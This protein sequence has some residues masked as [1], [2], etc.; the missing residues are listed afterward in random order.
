MIGLVGENIV[1]LNMTSLLEVLSQISGIPINEFK[2]K[3]YGEYMRTSDPEKEPK[4]PDFVIR[5]KCGSNIA[6]IEVS[7]RNNFNEA[8]GHVV[9]QVNKRFMGD[10]FKDCLYGI[11]VAI[12]H[13]YDRSI[14]FIKVLLRDR[15]GIWTDITDLVYSRMR[16]RSHGG[17]D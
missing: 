9:K 1:K 14:A 10:R 17:V 6:F 2:S 5:N 8:L 15:N 16:E 3:H 11:A 4:I 7:F 12:K 13:D